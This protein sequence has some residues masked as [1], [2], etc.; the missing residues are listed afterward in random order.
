MNWLTSFVRPKIRGL[1]G[2]KK[3]IPDNLWEKCPGCSAMLFKREL[4]E[5]LNVCQSCGYHLKLDPVRRLGS[6]FDDGDY[7]EID[8][9]KVLIDP[10]QFRDQKRY[11]D[12]LKSALRKTR[13][14]DAILAAEGTVGGQK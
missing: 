8:I 12:R 13:R 14:R 3:E 1:I 5:N 4:E 11:T 7:K 9:P 10:L 2:T 6:L